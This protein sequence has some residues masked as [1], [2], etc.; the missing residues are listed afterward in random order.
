[1]FNALF[2]RL[3]EQRNCSRKRMMAGYQKTKGEK[4]QKS[5]TKSLKAMLKCSINKCHCSLCGLSSWESLSEVT[6]ADNG[7]LCLSMPTDKS[8]CFFFK[9]LALKDLRLP[10][11]KRTFLGL[12]C[13]ENNVKR[14]KEKDTLTWL[15]SIFLCQVGSKWDKNGIYL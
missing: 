3:T 7:G 8:Y 15:F 10:E 1:M 13:L 5:E 11:R 12:S 6:A 14:D 2:S 9:W 4:E